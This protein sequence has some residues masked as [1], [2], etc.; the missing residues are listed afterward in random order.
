[1]KLAGTILLSLY[2]ILGESLAIEP[3]GTIGKGSLL[4]LTYLPDG[5]MLRVMLRHIEIVDPDNDVVLAN[6]A[7]SPDYFWSVI[8]SPDGRQLVI[9]RWNMV[10]FWDINRQKKLG[11]SEFESVRSWSVGV[12]DHPFLVAFART[13]SLLAMNNGTDEI[14]LR[15]WQTGEWVGRLEDKRR[16]CR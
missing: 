4:R 11:E 9:R 8:V 1:M 13:Q 16:T 14:F 12:L 6:F 3:I 7:G 15:D 5:N 10:E 2:L